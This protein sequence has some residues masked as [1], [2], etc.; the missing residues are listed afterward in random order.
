MEYINQLERLISQSEGQA[1]VVNSYFQWFSFDIMG[2]IAFS[3]S[4][5][6]L[7]N[8]EWHHAI[9]TLRSGMALVG[10]FTPV[11]WLMQLGSEF[12]STSL[13]RM[14]VWC[15]QQMDDRIKVLL[16]SVPL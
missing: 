8:G 11:P 5:N 3:K 6:M 2:Q 4:F 10:P 14:F 12:P 1:I 15:T 7:E 9:Q 16:L 13:K